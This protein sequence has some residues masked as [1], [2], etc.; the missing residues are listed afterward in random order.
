MECLSSRS[1]GDDSRLSSGSEVKRGGGVSVQAADGKTWCSVTHCLVR[2]LS[3]FGMVFTVCVRVFV[4]V[5]MLMFLCT[6]DSALLGSVT[7]S[8]CAL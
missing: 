8:V 5:L 4:C 1:D 2:R 3:V 7:V 6:N